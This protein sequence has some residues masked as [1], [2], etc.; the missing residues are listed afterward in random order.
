MVP[1]P[2]L[3]DTFFGICVTVL[4]SVLA[5]VVLTAAESGTDKAVVAGAIEFSREAFSVCWAKLVKPSVVK[6][7]INVSFSFISKW[8]QNGSKIQNS[9]VLSFNGISG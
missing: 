1:A 8:L 5:S 9:A 3:N 6:R 7:A 4:M 2:K